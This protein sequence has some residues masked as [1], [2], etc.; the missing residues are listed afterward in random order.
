MRARTHTDSLLAKE[1]TILQG[2][3][4][5][6]I[7][8]RKC[9][10]LEM[11]VEKT[12]VMRI[13]RLPSAVQVMVDQKQLETVEYFNYL[14]SM[15]KGNA[16]CMCK[17]QNCHGKISIQQEE[18]TFLWQIGLIFKGKTTKVLYIEHSFIWC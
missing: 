3:I 2:K 7:G 6:L 15:I 8:I 4:D 13:S 17:I 16:R 1:E 14:S 18:D 11:N 9:C 12:K 5:G 10:G